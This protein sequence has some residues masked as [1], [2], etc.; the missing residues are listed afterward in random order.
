M[1]FR[2]MA[3]AASLVTSLVVA[4]CSPAGG[5][6]VKLENGEPGAGGATRSVRVGSTNFGEQVILAEAYAQILE[7]NGYAVERKLNLGNREIVQPALESSQIDLYPE[8]LATMLAFVSKGEKKGSTDAAETHR[9]LEEN[10]KPRGIAVL[11]FAPGVNTSG[12]VTTRPTADTYKLSKVSD[13]A[14]IGDRL[15][16]GG[17]PECLQ[18]PFC[19]VGLRA[20]YGITFKDFR[21]LDVR[22]PL[23]TAAL[24][25]GQIDV[26]VVYTTDA[27]I[28]ARGWVLLEDDKKLQLA[29]NI[30]PVVRE[31]LLSKAPADFRT[32]IN[33]LAPK[34]TTAALTE[35]NRKAD[36]DRQDPKRVAGDWLKENGLVK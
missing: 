32:L 9:L 6:W 3:V 7:A 30:A 31:D 12:F 29:D 14:P 16:L 10:L 15:V 36:V 24:E 13:L 25:G 11:D 1:R 4:A 26:A 28:A 19:L 20:T 2:F 27:K 22:G 21:P 8:Y 34:L 23:T 35:M 17:P 5:T 18:R 33:S